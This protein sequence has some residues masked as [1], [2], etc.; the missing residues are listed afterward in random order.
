MLTDTV[1]VHLWDVDHDYY[2][3]ENNY[4]SNDCH[5]E[6]STWADFLD[7]EGDVDMD[8][9]LLF[10]WDWKLPDPESEQFTDEL[11]LFFIGQRKG[12]F[13]SVTVI[14]HP[15]DESSVREWLLPRFSRMV[16]LWKPLY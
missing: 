2:C 11:Q 5:E 13:R 16:T 1:S 10:R 14:V 7:E 15:D 9:N 6:Y 3:N 8:Y 4:F 12:L